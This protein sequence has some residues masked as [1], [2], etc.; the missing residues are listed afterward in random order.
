MPVEDVRYDGGMMEHSRGSLG[1]TQA[2]SILKIGINCTPLVRCCQSLLLVDLGRRNLGY[3]WK[4]ERC[5]LI[6]MT[7]IL[8]QPPS[9]RPKHQ[10]YDVHSSQKAFLDGRKPRKLITKR[11]GRI[12]FCEKRHVALV[13]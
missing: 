9:K 10:I 2:F 11:E 6:T 5:L 4:D 3:G 7:D 8:S 1:T 13:K 12:L